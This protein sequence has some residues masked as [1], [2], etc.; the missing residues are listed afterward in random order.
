MG[1]HSTFRFS[2]A[3]RTTV[4]LGAKIPYLFRSEPPARRVLMQGAAAAPDTHTRNSP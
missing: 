4:A 2:A 1:R 3:G